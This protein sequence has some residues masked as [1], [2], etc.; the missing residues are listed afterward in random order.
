M[1]SFKQGGKRAW[2]RQKF[3]FRDHALPYLFTEMRYSDI[4]MVLKNPFSS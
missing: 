3:S 1:D 4:L 2:Q